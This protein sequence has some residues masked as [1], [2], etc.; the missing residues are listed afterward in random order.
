MQ[1]LLPAFL[2][3]AVGA[4][5][6]APGWL[7]SRSAPA[8]AAVELA[9]AVVTGRVQVSGPG[10]ANPVAILATADVEILV[11]PNEFHEV[12]VGLAGR[13]VEL[14]GLLLRAGRERPSLWVEA[15][16]LRPAEPPGPG[17]RSGPVP[18]T[19]SMVV[20]DREIAI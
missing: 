14:E 8:P 1:R 12:V 5:L 10:A 7:G 15:V 13:E 3:L 16:N 4:A 6:F 2:A 18:P 17:L 11:L 19:P 20:P 9:Y